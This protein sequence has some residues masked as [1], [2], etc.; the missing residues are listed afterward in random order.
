M[1]ED[2]SHLPPRKQDDLRRIAAIIRER[3]PGAGLIILFGS[4][5]RGG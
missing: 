3:C 5:A 2:L 1:N 4:Y